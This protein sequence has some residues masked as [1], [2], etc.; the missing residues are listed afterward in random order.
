MMP[1]SRKVYLSKNFKYIVLP[2]HLVGLSGALYFL[3]IK[4]EWNLLLWSYFSWIIIGVLGVSLVYHKIFSHKSFEPAWYFRPF[5]YLLTFCGM[6]SGQG[7]PLSY[8]AVHRCYHHPNSDQNE[9]DP[10]S[11]EVHGFLNAYYGWHFH[12]KRITFNGI[13]D[14]L[15]DKILRFCHQN[16]YSFFWLVFFTSALIS[17][18]FLIFCVLIP[19]MVHLHQMNILNSFSHRKW[20]GYRNFDI[21]DHSVNNFIFGILTFGTGFHNNHHAHPKRWHNQVKWFEFD[22]FRWIVPLIKK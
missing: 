17:P 19:G 16:Y 5:M 6:L 11:P 8:S 12:P 3:I 15:D 20:F 4:G 7:S 21:E 14:L 18:R 13:R 1:K 9:S 22:P 10:H 2:Q